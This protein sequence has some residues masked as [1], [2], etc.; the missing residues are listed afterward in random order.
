LTCEPWKDLKF[1]KIEF[2]GATGKIG[3]ALS[4]QPLQCSVKLD[5]ARAAHAFVAT[6]TREDG[7]IVTS[8]PVHVIVRDPAVSA[9]LD[10]Q[11]AKL[12]DDRV[13]HDP[14]A[15]SLPASGSPAAQGD[16]VLVAG[17][18]TEHD[19]AALNLLSDTLPDFWSRQSDQATITPSKHSGRG[20]STVEVSVKPVC[21]PGGLYLHFSASYPGGV[22]PG[23]ED[24]VD[25]HIAR[26]SATQLWAGQPRESRF[27]SLQ[28]SLALSESQYQASFGTPEAPSSTLRRTYPKP[29]TMFLGQTIGDDKARQDYGIVIK[30]YFPSNHQRSMTWF[31][32]WD[33]VGRPAPMGQPQTGARLALVLGYNQAKATLR[34][35]DGLDPWDY[36]VEKGPNP[37]PWGELVIGQPVKD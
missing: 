3:Q 8:Y 23:A 5:G 19:A 31:I 16:A 18:I 37:N 4:G 10:A 26:D 20:K 35:P 22:A 12:N 21:A 32:P 11:A 24:G 7:S 27:S 25:F 28:Y 33:Y 13:Q 15:P 30:R 34:W 2:Y 14:A 36:A 17:I 1:Q 9:R 6:A 29:F